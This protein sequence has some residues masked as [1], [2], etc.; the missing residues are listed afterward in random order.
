MYIKSK[1]AMIYEEIMLPK[2]PSYVWLL[3]K[4][5]KQSSS[6]A[7]GRNNCLCT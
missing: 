6:N 5:V 1:K 3:M 7:I 2:K 4:N